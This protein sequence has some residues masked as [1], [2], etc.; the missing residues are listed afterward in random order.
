MKQTIL[1]H[2]FIFL[3]LP[4]FSQSVVDVEILD[5]KEENYSLAVNYRVHISPEAIETSQS[6]QINPIVQAGDSVLVLPGVTILGRNKQKVLFRSS[7]GDLKDFISS[8]IKSDT[9]LTY[10]IK[11]PYLLWM[12]SACLVLRQELS[13]YRGQSTLTNYKLK[14]KVSLAH[15]EPYRVNPRVSFIFPQ[16]EEK[17]RERQDKAYLDFQ[18]GCSVIIPGYRRNPEE[19]MKIY[20]VIR[21]VVNNP[22]VI[23]QRLY[24][25]GYASPEGPYALNER[26]SRERAQALKEYIRNKFRLDDNLF[27][28]TSVT[29]DWDG[30]VKLIKASNMPQKEKVLDIIS[31]IDIHEGR[32][33][34]LMKLDKGIPY[35]LML[36]EMFGELRR[37][38]YRIDYMVR[39]YSIEQTRALLENNTG[40]LSQFEL[41]SL[42]LSYGKGSDTF[43]KLVMETIPRH[44]PDNEI[45]NNNAAA[46]MIICGELPTAKRYL[47]KAGQSAASL[48]NRGI[49]LMM[50]GNLEKSGEYFSQAQR[51]GSEEAAANLQEVQAKLGDN[52]K[53]E[54]Y[55]NRK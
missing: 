29:E 7:Q 48:N 26:L 45:A 3:C 12:D 20:D 1:V 38:E 42:A 24:I 33:A 53:I 49:I 55:K 19:L 9:V 37:V 50:E 10:T 28:I 54:R 14:D 40:S 41:Y 13:G 46:V 2:L 8:R 52:I 5:F 25:E 16:K 35:R 30:L 6:Y 44:F 32:E 23:L 43:N 17:H 51:L 4:L 31:A 18:A 34:A 27:K 21:D 36:K 11:V 47:E 22:D 15:Y 39:D